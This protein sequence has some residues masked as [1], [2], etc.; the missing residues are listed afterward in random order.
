[1]AYWRRGR[2]DHT[3]RKI[4]ADIKATQTH[5]WLCNRSID[6]NLAWPHPHSFSVDH[7][8]PVI[9]RPDLEYVRANCRGS[10]LRCNQKRGDGRR[11]QP[12]RKPPVKPFIVEGQP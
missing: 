5:C 7:I 3:R 6:P 10:H 4:A 8:L 12:R 2:A 1:M 11:R 9:L